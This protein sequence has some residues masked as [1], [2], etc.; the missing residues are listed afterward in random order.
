MQYTCAKKARAADAA[1]VLDMQYKFAV[2]NASTFP[3]VLF[4]IP[5]CD[6][7]AKGRGDL[8][9]ASFFSDLNLLKVGSNFR[10]PLLQSRVNLTV[11]HNGG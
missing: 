7:I 8:L 6:C 1:A 4:E 2:A 3:I 10:Q 11:L 9:F 5:N